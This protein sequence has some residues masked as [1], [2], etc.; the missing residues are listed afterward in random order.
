MLKKR[1]LLLVLLSLVIAAGA[2]VVANNYVKTSLARANGAMGENVT[3]VAAAMRI[4]YA[5]KVELRHV[6]TMEVPSSLLPPGAVRDFKEIEGSIVK[7]E[8]L[9]GEILLK[10]RLVGSGEGNSLAALVAPN[11]RAVTVRVN[12]VIGVGGFLLPGNFVDVI[13]TRL[14]Q[15]MSRRAVSETIIMMVKV[16]AVDQTATS[17][18]NEPVVVRAVTLELDPSEAETLAKWEEEGTLQLALRNPTDTLVAKE[19][20]PAPAPVAAPEPRKP[21]KRAAAPRPAP[22]NEVILIRGTKVQSERG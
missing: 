3:V 7:S 2:A 12:D 16:L 20:P 21:A 9:D 11:K 5:T 4:P 19:E 17:D 6:K 8:I 22:A 15:G 13:G 1:G 14:E 10:D 18:K